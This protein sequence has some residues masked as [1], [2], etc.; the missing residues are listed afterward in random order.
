MKKRIIKNKDFDLNNNLGDDIHS[1]LYVDSRERYDYLNYV[2][3]E[4][5]RQKSRQKEE[6]SK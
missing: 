1:Q 2:Y 6:L 4:K 5:N 3:E